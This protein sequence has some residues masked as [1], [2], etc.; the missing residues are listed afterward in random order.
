MS[1]SLRNEIIKRLE[2]RDNVFLDKSNEEVIN[3]IFH[4]LDVYQTEL[5]AQNE[6]LRIKEE[7]L[8]ELNEEYQA[9]FNNAPIPYLLLDEKL[10]IKR[11]NIVADGYFY[12]SGFNKRSKSFISFLAK[13]SMQKFFSWIEK[14]SYNEETLDLDL[15]SGKNIVRFRLRANEHLV[16]ENYIMLSLVDIQKETEQQVIIQM[17]SKVAAMGEMIGNIAHQWRQP[18]SIITTHASNLLLS[19]DIHKSV[20]KAKL[21]DCA[22]SIIKQ[23]LYLSQTIDDFRNFFK[24]D[25]NNKSVFNIKDSILK[26]NKLIQDTMQNNFIKVIMDLDD[27]EVLQNEAKL[28]HAFL[29]ICNN[30]KDAMIL[31]EINSAHRFLFITLKK[32]NNNAVISFKDSAGGIEPDILYKV[33]DPYFTTKHQSVGTGIGLYMTNQIITKHFEGT[34]KVRNSQY[35]Y[36]NIKLSGAEFIITLPLNYQK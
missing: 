6:E 28:I 1:H 25:I 36:N 21:V 26:T 16:K 32:I 10:V 20:S 27:I 9:L 2:Q 11:F 22:N 5:E 8:N 7:I 4:E 23:A 34:I 30:T 3:T 35:E 24:S 13:D 17:Q 14:K 33:F 18:L 12:L 31:N 29:N 19:Y 15:L